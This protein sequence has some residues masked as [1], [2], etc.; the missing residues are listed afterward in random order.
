MSRISKREYEDGKY[1]ASCELLDGNELLSFCRP[2][3]NHGFDAG[4]KYALEQFGIWKDGVRRIG[5]LE[6]PVGEILRDIRE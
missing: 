1:L 3:Y 5:C 4:F 6:T 2:S